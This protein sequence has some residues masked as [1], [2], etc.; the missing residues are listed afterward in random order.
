[1]LAYS[2]LE[3]VST[4]PGMMEQHAASGQQRGWRRL[5]SRKGTVVGYIEQWIHVNGIP[6]VGLCCASGTRSQAWATS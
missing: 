6:T 4:R 2:Q 5:M 3:V 1:M